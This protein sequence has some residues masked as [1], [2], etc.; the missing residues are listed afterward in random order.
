MEFIN[1]KLE[2]LKTIRDL[3]M[4]QHEITIVQ[5]L[6][7]ASSNYELILD[8]NIVLINEPQIL[9]LYVLVYLSFKIV[10]FDI[11]LDNNFF[12]IP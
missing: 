8:E 9:I 6:V 1:W 12:Q 10:N 2:F 7:L 11:Y 5:M 4:Y 3:L